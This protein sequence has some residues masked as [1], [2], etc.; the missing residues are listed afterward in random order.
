MDRWTAACRAQTGQS[1]VFENKGK[2]YFW[3]DDG[4]EHDDGAITGCVY[5]MLPNGNAREVS[6]FRI[7]GDGEVSS[8][9]HF[10]RQA[11]SPARKAA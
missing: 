4:R 11:V 3:E 2:S 10:L 1:N 6:K 8:A 9:P 7:D 5:L